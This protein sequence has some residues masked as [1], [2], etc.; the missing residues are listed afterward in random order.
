MLEVYRIIDK[1]GF[2]VDT[3]LPPLSFVVLVAGG[4]SVYACPRVF[5]LER[6]NQGVVKLKAKTM[7]G[8]YIPL[9][10]CA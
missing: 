2:T 9:T 8:S 3:T 4:V 10:L 5:I 6:E 7:M 1:I